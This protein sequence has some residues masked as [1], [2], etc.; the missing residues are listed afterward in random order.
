[1]LPNDFGNMNPTSTKPN[2][3]DCLN[4]VTRLLNELLRITLCFHSS[5]ISEDLVI[6]LKNLLIDKYIM[7]LDA[8]ST[9]YLESKKSEF[10]DWLSERITFQCSNIQSY[11]NSKKETTGNSGKQ[12]NFNTQNSNIEKPADQPEDKMESCNLSLTRI[13]ARKM[14]RYIYC[15][16]IDSF[17]VTSS[18]LQF[19]T[20]AALFNNTYKCTVRSSCKIVRRERSR[21]NKDTST[22]LYRCNCY[23]SEIVLQFRHFHSEKTDVPN[24]QTY[25]IGVFIKKQSISLFN[26]H[27]TLKK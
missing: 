26:K 24:I 7:Q 10:K 11:G 3:F 5:I 22:Q 2:T 21:K 4:D 23:T 6:T 12:F 19:E 18:T 17:N 20:A 14:R 13:N 16:E 15:T 9:Q 1:M 25:S 8:R 27:F